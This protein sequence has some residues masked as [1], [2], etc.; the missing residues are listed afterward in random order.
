MLNKTEGAS[1]VNETIAEMAFLDG[2]RCRTTVSD[3]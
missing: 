3:G 2:M 1:S